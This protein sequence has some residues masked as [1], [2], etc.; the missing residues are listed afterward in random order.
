MHALVYYSCPSLLDTQRTRT[1]K[2]IKWTRSRLLSSNFVA[3]FVVKNYRRISR[4]DFTMEF[5]K[6]RFARFDRAISE[7]EVL[8]WEEIYKTRGERRNPI[9]SP[10]RW[11]ASRV[12]HK[13]SEPRTHQLRRSFS[14]AKCRPLRQPLVSQI[15]T[16]IYL[17][18]CAPQGDE[19]IFRDCL[20]AP[21]NT[22]EQRNWHLFA[23]AR[24]FF[25]V[26]Y[27]P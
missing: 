18:K 10:A 19:L 4:N 8:A 16:H 17:A 15:I 12:P 3:H 14:Y 21:R 7:N 2:G 13:E 1:H 24:L 22:W 20:C 25:V 27:Y 6:I 11:H 9:L 5:R 26:R 23:I